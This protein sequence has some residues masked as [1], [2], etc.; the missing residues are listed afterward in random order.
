[1]ARTAARTVPGRRSIERG[2]L[3]VSGLALLAWLALLPRVLTRL[4]PL[5]GDEP[6]YVMTAISLLQDGDLDES[7]NYA[8]RDYEQFYPPD[9]L[10]PGWQG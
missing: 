10:P 9:P 2:L 3:V 5:T 4:D 6:F 8:Q 7:N 1:M